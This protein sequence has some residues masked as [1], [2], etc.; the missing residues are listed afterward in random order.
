VRNE[1]L[2]KYRNKLA[3][4]S[5]AFQALIPLA[6]A[7]ELRGLV[8]TMAD[9]VPGM[10]HAITDIRRGKVRDAFKYASDK[11]LAWSFGFSPLMSDASSVALAIAKRIEPTPYVKIRASSERTQMIELTNPS[12]EGVGAY[13]RSFTQGSIIQTCKVTYTGTYKVGIS[14][15]VNYESAAKQFGIT[16]PHL[17]PLAWELVPYSFVIDYF[18]NIGDVIND[19][20]IAGPTATSLMTSEKN[21]CLT[22]KTRRIVPTSGFA[23]NGDISDESYESGSFTR[24]LLATL[25]SRTFQFESF[26]SIGKI[27][28]VINLASIL[29][30]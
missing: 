11:W 24:A 15:G 26:G 27:K 6:E 20:F 16:I 7:K 23:V 2:S 3:D 14:A 19:T 4:S 5:G 8:N 21:V 29:A 18:T 10:L 13:S 17:F 25:P 9:S 30:K 1:A 12:D 28:R 22:H